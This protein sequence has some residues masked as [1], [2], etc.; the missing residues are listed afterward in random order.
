[1]DMKNALESV[2]NLGWAVGQLTTARQDPKGLYVIA[3]GDKAGSA[4][5]WLR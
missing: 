5:F 4:S 3:F 2:P 1:V